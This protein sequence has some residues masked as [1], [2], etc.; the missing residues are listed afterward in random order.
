MIEERLLAF[1]ND[2]QR[3]GP[4]SLVLAELLHEAV[5]EIERLKKIVATFRGDEG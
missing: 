2:L 3:E 5:A 4:S 1:A